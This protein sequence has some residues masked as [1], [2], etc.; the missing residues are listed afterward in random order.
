[1]PGI[2]GNKRRV[3]DDSLFY[4]EPQRIELSLE[5]RPDRS[6]RTGFRQSFSEVP[7]R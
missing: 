5:F 3:L 4:F 1:M 7:D 2:S 6:I